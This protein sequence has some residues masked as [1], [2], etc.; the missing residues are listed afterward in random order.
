MKNIESISKIENFVLDI[1]IKVTLLRFV[2][3]L[4][5]GFKLQCSVAFMVMSF[6]GCIRFYCMSDLMSIFFAETRR[7]MKQCL[8]NYILACL[9]TVIF[10]A[11]SCF[12][13]GNLCLI[14]GTIG[15][16]VNNVVI[17]IGGI[18]ESKERTSLTRRR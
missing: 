6:L 15:V 10:L 8:F 14:C 7:R 5:A 9:L 11:I 12:R 3:M 18:L 2:G 1:T 17:I 4:L 16:M 13:Y